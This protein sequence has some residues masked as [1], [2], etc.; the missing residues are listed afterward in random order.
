MISGK[1]TK[2]KQAEIQCISVSPSSVAFFLL[3]LIISLI[4][5]TLSVLCS[6][7]HISFYV[8]LKAVLLLLFLTAS[9]SCSHLFLLLWASLLKRHTQTQH[10]SHP[11]ALKLPVVRRM[12][13]SSFCSRLHSFLQV[14][15]ILF[16]TGLSVIVVH[17]PS[18]N[19]LWTTSSR[20]FFSVFLT[21]RSVDDKGTRGVWVSKKRKEKRGDRGSG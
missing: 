14:L 9:D 7:L 13:E 20:I 2:Q 17:V 4:F 8:L 6:V 5:L 3:S 18:G 15:Q 10:R 1:K 19:L 11:T 16:L 12:D 21:D